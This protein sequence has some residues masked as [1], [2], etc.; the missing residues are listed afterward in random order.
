MGFF[1]KGQAERPKNVVPASELA[2][3][4]T[5]GRMTF[6][7]GQYV[8]V[9]GFYLPGLL[10]A[11]TP[12]PGSTAYNAFIDRLLDDLCSAAYA[13]GDW[14]LA[15]ALYVAKDFLGSDGLSHQQF[16]FLA[17]RALAFMASAGVSGGVIPNFLMERWMEARA[18]TS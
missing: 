16:A 4:S 9:S 8:D 13:S 17:D 18:G 6:A 10:A 1:S 11:G 3:L 7:E 2:R 5:V 12:S 14:A 15:G